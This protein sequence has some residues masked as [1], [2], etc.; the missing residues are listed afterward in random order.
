MRPVISNCG[1]STKKASE[2]LDNHLKPIMQSSWSYIRDSGDFIDEIN[3]IENI[4]KDVILVMADVIGLYLCILMSL[5]EG[6]QKRSR[7]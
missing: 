7:C 6:S 2:F 3:R 5:F 1:T 4:S